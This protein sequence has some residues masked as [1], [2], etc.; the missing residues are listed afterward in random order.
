MLKIENTSKK[1][2]ILLVNDTRIMERAKEL[3]YENVC[4]FPRDKLSK[5]ETEFLRHRNLTA[6]I[7]LYRPGMENENPNGPAH[8]Y[9]IKGTEQWIL[10]YD[11]YDYEMPDGIV[12]RT[13]DDAVRFLQPPEATEKYLTGNGYIHSTNYINRCGNCHAGFMKG[14]KYCRCCGTK[15]GEGKFLPYLNTIE[16]LYGAPVKKK[17]KCVQCGYIWVTTNVRGDDSFYC[18]AC[19]TDQIKVIRK[20]A[21]QMLD[22]IGYL[23]PYD[24]ENPPVMLSEDEVRYF[25][26]CRK[27]VEQEYSNI[28]AIS[29][30]KLLEMMRAAGMD[31]PAMTDDDYYYPKKDVDDE[32]LYLLRQ[33]LST[34]GEHPDHSHKKKCPNCRSVMITALSYRL[35]DDDGYIQKTDFHDAVQENSF[36]TNTGTIIEKESESIPAYM[37]FCCGKQ[38]GGLKY[39]K[40]YD[41]NGPSHENE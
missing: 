27:K 4:L 23:D 12:I 8:R 41:T 11:L 6:L 31:V 28:Y 22:P 35:R 10:Q 1:E 38:F 37:C 15:R 17:F 29:V 26:D 13:I 3:G 40:G 36:L 34:K 14:D 24:E 16:V 5:E 32:R 2:Y 19:G 25:L 18:P 30:A 33:I 39:A 9:R 7:V 21:T 20:R